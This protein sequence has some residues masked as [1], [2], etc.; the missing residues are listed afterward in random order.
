MAKA[1][2]CAECSANVWVAEDGSCMNGHPA[3]AVSNVYDTDTPPPAT[4]VQ[5]EPAPQPAAYT[6]Q[7]VAAA[8]APAKSKKTLWIVLAVVLVL[9]C[10]LCGVVAAIAIPAFRSAQTGASQSTCFANERTIEGAYQQYLASEATAEPATD[11]TSLRTLLEGGSYLTTWPTCPGG[12]TY[13]MQSEPDGVR[14][15]CSVHGSYRGAAELP[16]P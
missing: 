2:Y 13:S 14:I 4:K 16:A 9:G 5:P 3:S 10:C 1:G 15:Q 11:L 6:P 12:G 7:P 8:P